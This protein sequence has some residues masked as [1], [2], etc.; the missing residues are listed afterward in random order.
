GRTLTLDTYG[1]R[2]YTIVGVMPQ[3]FGTPSQCELWLPMGWMGVTLDSRR[4]AHWH[5]IIARLKPG[6]TPDRAQAE[7]NVIQSRIKA[8]HPGNTIDSEVAVIPLLKQALGRNLET[9]LMV[10][11]ATV[12]AVLLI[13]CANIA[14]LLLARAATRQK[15]IALC[16]ALGAGRWR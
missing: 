6:V 15:E 1:K 3:G 9:A 13:A 10:L 14:S 2:D 7:L 8:T 12:A 16:V 4:S 11:W 5:N